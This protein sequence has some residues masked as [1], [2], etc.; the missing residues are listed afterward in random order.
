MRCLS[1]GNGL[2]PGAQFCELC[3]TAVSGAVG[4]TSTDRSTP[5][6]RHDRTGDAAARFQGATAQGSIGSVPVTGRPN[7]GYGTR[8]EPTITGGSAGYPPAGMPGPPQKSGSGWKWFGVGGSA[9]A[10]IA[11][12]ALGAFML[13]GKAASSKF[14]AVGPAVDIQ[15][16]SGAT[17]DP[18]PVVDRSVLDGSQWPVA[19]AWAEDLCVTHA[20]HALTSVETTS[21]KVAICVDD[22]GGYHY[23]GI[24]RSDEAK[25]W[26]DADYSASDSQFTA[27]NQAAHPTT[28]AV[29][30]YSLVISTDGRLNSYE[31]VTGASA[32]Q[33]SQATDDELKQRLASLLQASSYGRSSLKSFLDATYT[34]AACT[35]GSEA[36]AMIK[37]VQDNRDD[38]AVAARELQSAARG[39]VVERA[40]NAFVDAMDASKTVDDDLADWVD[41]YW[42]DYAKSGCPGGVTQ[43]SD[44]YTD[45]ES[46]NAAAKAAKQIVV[47]EF[48][49]LTA[50]TDLYHD[51]STLDI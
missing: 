33:Q 44:V 23:Q 26:L 47:D 42:S 2:A 27:V 3:G 29:T 6:L 16:Q 17:A 28:Y 48:R 45:W 5:T 43:P 9:A 8:V 51:W 34:G 25:N 46:A 50:G 11:L 7:G 32:P 13:T 21:S 40:A 49:S 1:C 19:A 36:A 12:V 18:G 24:R 4:S 35:N 37:V 10:L 30:P 38:M 31:S 41:S 20:T 39:T 22:S 14:S 15:E